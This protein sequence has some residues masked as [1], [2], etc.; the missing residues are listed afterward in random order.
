MLKLAGRVM[1]MILSID[2]ALDCQW[3]AKKEWMGKRNNKPLLDGFFKLTV[4]VPKTFLSV[5]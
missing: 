2:K 1:W 3:I 5:T 4:D